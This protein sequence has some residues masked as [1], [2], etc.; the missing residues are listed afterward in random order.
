MDTENRPVLTGLV[1]LVGVAV[2]IGL[3]GG[4]AVLVGVKAAGIGDTTEA[5]SEP[6]SSDSISVLALPMDPAAPSTVQAA[7]GRSMPR[8]G[9][10]VRIPSAAAA[11]VNALPVVTGTPGSRRA[12]AFRLTIDEWNGRERLQMVVEALA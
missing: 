6:T 10:A 1:A 12:S 8:A 11:A 2:V 9:A 4:L 7:V 5:T 3:L